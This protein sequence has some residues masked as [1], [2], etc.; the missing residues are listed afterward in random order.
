MI[1]EDRKKAFRREC[2]QRLR[3]ASTVGSYAKDKKVLRVL[4]T[5][6]VQSHAQNVML[7]LPL[8]ME[9]NLYPL[10]QRLRKEE[11][12]LYVPFMEGASFRLVKYRLPLLE[13]KFGIKEPKDSKQFRKKQIDIAIVPI[14]GVDV[15]HRRVGFGKGMYDRFFEKNKKNIKQVVFVA[16]ELCYAKEIVTDHYDV[17]ADM[18]LTP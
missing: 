8:E 14:V 12:N 11:R 18:I 3:K 13:K 5:H 15:T 2:L 17:K 10:I 7:Y 1:K 16:R 4:Y 9:V 6:I